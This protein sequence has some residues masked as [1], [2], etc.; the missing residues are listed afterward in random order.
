MA[1]MTQ[2]ERAIRILQRLSV[3]SRVT[4]NELYELFERRESKR[5]LQRTLTLIENANVP[6]QIEH[7]AHNETYYSLKGAFDFTPLMLTPE[8][9]I[10]ASL[11]SQFKS[12]FT[13]TSI[14]KDLE[15][16]F[17]K[18]SQLFPDDSIVVHQQFGESNGPVVFKDTG[19]MNLDGRGQILH[20][21][22]FAITRRSECRIKYRSKQFTIQP[23]TLLFHNGAL[24]A[25]VFQPKHKEWIYLSLTRIGS[26]EV[27]ERVFDRDPSF[28]VNELLKDNFGIWREEPEDVT[29]H[30]SKTVRHSIED[31]IWHPSQRIEE[32]DS[33]DILLH[34]HVGV[35]NELVAWILKW[36]EFAEVLQPMSLR[37]TLHERLSK[38][39]EYYKT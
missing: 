9:V 1:E 36:G 2:L 30:F 15:T 29:I 38:T 35:S 27:T 6:L 17:E 20:D 10:A 25:I 24:Y 8:E 4:I 32:E 37:R 7:G 34:M 16:V 13:G 14:G 12:I 22:F 31:R 3:Y 33:G 26:V 19:R 18:L 28:D 5:T 23:Y 39:R 11:L 21:L